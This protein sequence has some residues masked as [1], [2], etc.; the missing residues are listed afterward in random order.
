MSAIGAALITGG[1]SLLGG[2]FGRKKQTQKTETINRPPD[3][4]A[5]RAE[6]ERGKYNP[7]TFLRATGGTGG[8]GTSTTTSGGALSSAS[9]IADAITDGFSAWQ[10]AKR[11]MDQ[12]AADALK[13]DIMR[14][15][16]AMMQERKA[17]PRPG[18]YGFSIPTVHSTGVS[19][20]GRTSQSVAPRL[21]PGISMPEGATR[22]GGTPGDITLAPDGFPL[23]INRPIPLHPEETLVRRSDNLTGAN[24]EAPAEFETDVWTWFREGTA[25]PNLWEVYQRNTMTQ[26]QRD[27]VARIRKSASDWWNKPAPPR[28]KTSDL[29]VTG[30]TGPSDPFG[31]LR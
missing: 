1:A 24:P 25:I 27:R 17:G 15:E 10:N 8:G 19:S 2:L 3:G 31:T 18:G 11:D 5:I 14:E 22:M 23:P 21:S 4:A 20:T 12:E 28:R 13:M 30:Y 29:G 26:K 7:L 6:A 16:L 9:W